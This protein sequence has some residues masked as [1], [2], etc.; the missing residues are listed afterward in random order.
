M[1]RGPWTMDHRPWTGKGIKILLLFVFL[2]HSPLSTVHG[3]SLSPQTLSRGESKTL[4]VDYEIGDVAV[5]DPEVVDFAVQ[6]NRRHI[7]LNARGEGA[8][9][10]TLWDSEGKPRDAVPITV[11]GEDLNGL[12]QAARRDFGYFPALEF[13]VE[14]RTIRVVG[15]APSHYVYE[16]LEEF[17]AKH[18]QI[19]NEAA[20]AEPVLDTLTGSIEKAIGIPGIKV[21]PVRNRIVLEGV[22]YSQAQANKALEIAKLYNPNTLNLI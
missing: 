15:N 1:K 18:P 13:L 8:A 20:I 2:V 12:L 3:Q 17:A 11:Y 22:A 21:R 7:Y 6:D 14:D 9:T 5:T 16:R 4:T 10:L 19:I